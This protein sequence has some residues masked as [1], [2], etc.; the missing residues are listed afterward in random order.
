V[1]SLS[2]PS[3]RLFS[4]APAPLPS[5]TQMRRRTVL[6]AWRGRKRRPPMAIDRRASGALRP[7]ADFH[8]DHLRMSRK[9]RLRQIHACRLKTPVRSGH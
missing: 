6:T 1:S 7:P 4:S 9:P 3:G 8:A 2:A 5:A